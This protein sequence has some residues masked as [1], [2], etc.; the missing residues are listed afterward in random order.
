[1]SHLEYYNNLKSTVDIFRDSHLDLLKSVCVEL[2]VMD[3]YDGLV[4][5]YIDKTINLKAKKDPNLP[6]KQRNKFLIF[7]EHERARMKDNNEKLSFSDMTKVLSQRWKSLSDEDQ[8]KYL[9]IANLDKDRYNHEM[10]LYRNNLFK[11]NT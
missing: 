4:S 1:M 3:K 8:K 10:D 11:E 9:D 6:K 5:K 7:C 2:N